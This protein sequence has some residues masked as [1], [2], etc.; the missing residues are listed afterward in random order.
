MFFIFQ[1]GKKCG[2]QS[3]CSVP[4]PGTALSESQSLSITLS[5]PEPGTALSESQSLNITL[6]VPEPGTALRESRSLSIILS[7]QC[8]IF[9]TNLLDFFLGGGF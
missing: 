1:T 6:S 2:C 4:E 7:N 5:V 3:D 8:T 9:I